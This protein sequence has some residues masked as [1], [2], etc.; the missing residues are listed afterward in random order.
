MSENND[1]V[2]TDDDDVEIHI[3]QTNPFIHTVTLLTECA[4]KFNQWLGERAAGM[5]T[6][7]EIVHPNTFITVTIHDRDGKVEAQ[8]RILTFANN[9]DYS[10]YR[11]YDI[12]SMLI[13]ALIKT[14]NKIFINRLM[15]PRTDSVQS[16]SGL[17]VS[18]QYPLGIYYTN[19]VPFRWSMS[20]ATGRL[21]VYHAG[22]GVSRVVAEFSS[23]DLLMRESTIKQ[24]ANYIEALECTAL[25]IMRTQQY[26]DRL[27]YV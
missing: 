1:K 24:S 25:V 11:T 10:P 26:I 18:K 7:I 20:P 19:G 14:R 22:T 9:S 27:S 12:Y 8:Q 13:D 5:T 2:T 23:A 16:Y 17:G 4:A 15:L 3:D 21:F 6:T